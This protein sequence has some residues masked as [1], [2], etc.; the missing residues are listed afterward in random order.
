MTDQTD[1]N[2]GE[3]EL[4]RR[5]VKA[6]VDERDWEQFH[7]P[8]NLSMAM[9]V[10]AGELV[11]IFQWL[12]ERQSESPDPQRMRRIEEEMADVLVYLIRLADRLNVDLYEAAN[13]KIAQNEAKYPAD[14]V[15]GSS[16]KYQ[17]YEN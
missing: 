11:E 14:K 4:L 1:A 2:V 5:R 17:E 12:T 6:F 10:E 16:K 15:R 7:S 8:K 9:I 13:R 3:F